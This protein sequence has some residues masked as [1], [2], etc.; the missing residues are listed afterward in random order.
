MSH[1]ARR[2]PRLVGTLVILAA[3]LAAGPASC[4]RPPA[5]APPEGTLPPAPAE[6]RPAEFSRRFVEITERAG[7][8]FRH[9]T[10]GTGEKLLPETMGAGAAFLD[11]DG[12]GNLDLFLVG[13]GAWPGSPVPE[14]PRGRCALYR[15]RGDGT[16]L[17]VTEATGAGVVCYGM[18]CAVA[19]FD[20][21][22][23]SDL[24]LTTLGDNVLLRND[25]GVFTDVTAAAGV[26]GGRWGGTGEAGT[27]PGDGG[28][29]EWSTG[30]TWLDVDGD[31]DL[32]LFV[33]NY[34]AWSPER[35]IFTTLDGTTKAFTTPDHYDGLPCR[36]FLQREPG[37]FED[38][39]E[40]AGTARFIGKSLGV[41]VWDLDGDRRLDIVVANDT[42]PNFLFA[43]RGGGR[44]EERGLELGIAYDEQ[45]RAR[46]GM[47]IDIAEYAGD[48]VPGVAIGNFADESISL[49]RREPRGTFAAAAAGA[50]L[51]LATHRPLAFAVAFLDLD[52]DGFEDL[53]VVNGHI[54]PDIARFSPGH[55][56][57]QSSQLFAGRP[58]GRFEEV[59]DHV[60]TDFSCPRVGRG[61]AAGDIDGD[62]DL[63]LVITTNGGSPVLLRNDPAPGVPEPHFLR[64]RLLGT[65]PNTTAI[66]ARV[67]LRTGGRVQTRF[68]RTGSSYLSESETPLTFGLGSATTVEEFTVDWPGGETRTYA[69]EGIDRTLL[70]EGPGREESSERPR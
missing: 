19:D 58:G 66:G 55:T 64:V 34:V 2:A 12:D 25:D 36:L 61:L 62:G 28:H 16:F 4:D 20:G 6:D 17:D 18:G 1:R 24:Y 65:P 10:G 29:P 13:S 33:A 43:N 27:G 7:I 56:H 51:E 39:S 32:D 9:D 46:A 57:A 54:E 60:G 37:R 31:G 15:G 38:V 23:D 5:N 41:A 53:V 49:Y 3:A 42:R 14:T 59:G 50:G 40:A 52:L 69:V 22:G 48:G 63:D 8:R 35:E 45:G 21:D 67:R 68:V 11:H 70:I 47:G 26:A 30:A 44:L